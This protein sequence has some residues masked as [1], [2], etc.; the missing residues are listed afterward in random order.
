MEV[1]IMANF[2]KNHKTLY[3]DGLVR[4]Q[5]AET[6]LAMIHLHTIQK[7]QNILMMLLKKKFQKD[8]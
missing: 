7:K 8:S 6:L 4:T 3:F 2:P 1:T 5:K